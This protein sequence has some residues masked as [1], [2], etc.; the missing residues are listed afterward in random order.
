MPSSRWYKWGLA[1]GGIFAAATL[2]NM[3]WA[4]PRLVTAGGLGV[5]EISTGILKAVALAFGLGFVGGTFVGLVAPL[6]GRVGRRRSVAGGALAAPT[7]TLFGI[8]I[9]APDL[10]QP[11]LLWRC[12]LLLAIQALLGGFLGAVVFSVYLETRGDARRK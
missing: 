2:I 8:W 9:G 3:A 10:L 5:V 4:I 12:V 1:G 7:L 11:N 6:S